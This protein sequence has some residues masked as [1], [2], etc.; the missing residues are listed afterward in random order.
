MGC[1]SCVINGVRE[2]KKWVWKKALFQVKEYFT[3]IKMIELT[4]KNKAK[5]LERSQRHMFND[6][7]NFRIIQAL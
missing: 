6:R 4:K 5:A 1:H 3:A 2:G 7:G